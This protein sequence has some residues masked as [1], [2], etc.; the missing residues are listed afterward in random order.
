LELGAPPKTAYD[1]S[2]N[3][4]AASIAIFKTFI[5]VLLQKWSE[6]GARVAVRKV[7]E[8]AAAW[9]GR[10]ATKGRCQGGGKGS[11]H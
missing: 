2:G 6:H 10:I 9:T 4:V 8:N 3:S 1:A 7:S 5:T 11:S